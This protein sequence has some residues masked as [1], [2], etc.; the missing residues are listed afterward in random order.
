MGKR[1]VKTGM[2]RPERLRWIALVVAALALVAVAAFFEF[3]PASAELVGGAIVA[4]PQPVPDFTLTDQFGRSQ[5]LSSLRGKP[6]ALT[7]VY[8]HCPDVCPLISAN[9][10]RA[11]QMLGDRATQVGLVAVT[12]D[13]EHD[14]V[15]QAKDFSD[16]LGLTDEWYFLTGNRPQLEGIWAAYGIS[17]QAVAAQAQAA[18]GSPDQIEHSAPI[19]IIDKRGQARA[20]LPVDVTADD[21]A[22]DLGA[23]IAER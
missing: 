6:V 12:V 9:M 23:L 16:K 10:H 21:I 4:T 1:K 19:Y 20:L 2:A 3:R 14:T 11:Y 17:A 15:Q 13:P 22:T 7:F 5:T 18:K 8:T